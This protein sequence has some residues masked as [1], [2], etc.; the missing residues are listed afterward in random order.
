VQ[1]LRLLPGEYFSERAR[2][3]VRD[4][5]PGLGIRY[6]LAGLSYDP[7]NPDLYHRLGTA[8]L[9][10]GRTMEDPLAA[11]SFRSE[12]IR[13]YEKA[14]VLAPQEEIYALELA[15]ALDE[16][17]RFEEAEGVFYEV[18]Q[19]DPKSISIRRYY[20]HHLESWRGP[21]APQTD[22]RSS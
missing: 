8:R 1:S 10:F 15:S 21:I 9:Q 13:A 11:E 14:R 12:A 2:M 4:Q 16:A 7:Q 20:E 18:L 17:E 22:E 3:A 6:A 5:Q 19:L